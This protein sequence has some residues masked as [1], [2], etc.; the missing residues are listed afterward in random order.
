MRRTKNN[1]IAHYDH[2]QKE[3]VD[4]E[5]KL[6]EACT[7]VETLKQ[8]NETLKEDRIRLNIDLKLEI[9]FT[10][11]LKRLCRAQMMKENK[12]FD[13]W[14]KEVANRKFLEA[15]IDTLRKDKK[16]KRQEVAAIWERVEGVGLDK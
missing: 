5:K 16:R 8:S 10:Y 7:F 3:I 15:E 1:V 9:L 12:D 4:L 13:S 6:L 11:H 2:S 14:K